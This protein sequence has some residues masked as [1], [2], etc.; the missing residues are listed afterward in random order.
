MTD[1]TTA[2]DVPEG[3]L[4][5]FFGGEGG[6]APAITFVEKPK[7]TKVTG[8]VMPVD[9]FS[10]EKGYRTTAQ[11]NTKGEVLYW[12][13]KPGETTKRPRPQAEITLATEY[14]EREFMSDAAVKRAVE[15]EQVDDGLRRL[16]AKGETLTKGLKEALRRSG[17][18]PNLGPEPGSTIAVTIADRTPNDHGGKTN[19]FEV[20]YTPPTDATRAMVQA[21]IAKAMETPAGGQ[22]DEPPF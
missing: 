17:R 6:G 9:P 1:S 5:D 3:E 18:N 16:M 14:R 22:E 12:P 19:I 4:Q 20:E 7:G 11:R 13:L 10:P 21:Y 15:A 8:V 2:P